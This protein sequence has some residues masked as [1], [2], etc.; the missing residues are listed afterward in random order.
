M[1]IIPVALTLYTVRDELNRD[2]GETL[3]KIKDIGY[4]FIEIGGFGPYD[5]G[6]WKKVLN[7]LGM[8]IVS[9]HIEIEMLEQSL[10]HIAEFNLEIGN[11][12]LVVPYLREERRDADGFKKAAESMN[13]IG[14]RCKGLGMRL[15]YHNH[16]FE[17]AKYNGKT[18]HQILIENT[19]PRYVSFQFD[20]YWLQYGGENPAEYT[21][22][23]ADRVG[24]MHLKDMLDDGK[25]SFAEVGEGILD[26]VSIF[27]AAAESDVEWFA[28]EQDICRR[29]S[30]ESAKMSL[31]N[32]R[33]LKIDTGIK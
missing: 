33:K 13:N 4:D 3:R 29:P 9:N 25:K 6:E 17:F 26:F 15:Y 22:K 20:T 19:D 14:L 7:G 16:S 11:K 2:F 21:K 24:Y 31:E 28:V 8:K 18:G 30:L 23:Y 12:N 32:I 1:K 27:K 10:N 5:T